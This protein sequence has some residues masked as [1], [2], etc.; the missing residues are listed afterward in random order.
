[1][2]VDRD[3]QAAVIIGLDVDVAVEVELGFFPC[4]TAAIA[5]RQRLEGVKSR[6]R[7]RRA[8][9]L[10]NQAIRRVELRITQ[11]YRNVTHLRWQ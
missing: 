7:H 10:F 1:V 4:P 11:H 8:K 5:G 2:R 6:K 3:V 9:S